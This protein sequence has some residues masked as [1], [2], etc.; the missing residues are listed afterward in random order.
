MVYQYSCYHRKKDCNLTY[1]LFIVSVWFIKPSADLNDYVAL[2]MCAVR[3]AVTGSTA[4]VPQLDENF[5]LDNHKG[6]LGDDREAEAF[7]YT[8]LTYVLLFD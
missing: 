1:W 2:R 3:I 6:T 7:D 4:G 5:F 8:E